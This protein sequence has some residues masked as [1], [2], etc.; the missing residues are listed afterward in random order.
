MIGQTISHYRIVEKLG[1]GGMGVVY[2]AED[3]KLGRHVALKFL[4]DDLAKD[5]QALARFRREAKAASSL[6]HPNICTIHEIDESG[7][8]SFIAME[9]LEGQTLRHM[10]GGKPLEIGTMLDLGIQIADALDAAHSKAIIHRDIKPANIFVTNRGQAK[11]LDFGLVKVTTKPESV[12]FTE[13]TIEFEQSLTSPGCA[14]G[15]VAYMSPEQVRAKELDTRTDLFSFGAVLYEMCT[16]TLPF[17]GESSGV[18]FKAILDGTPASAMRLNPDLPGELERIVN[19]ALE[20]DCKLRYQHASEMRSE[21]QRFKRDNESSRQLAAAVAGTTNE[22]SI[23]V[24]PFTNMS[25]DPENEFFADGITEEIINALTQ[26]KDLRVA[27]RTSAFSFKGKHVDLRTI[28][29]RLNVRTVL[30]GSVRKAGNRVRIMAQL[31]NVADGYQ[32]WS[33]RYDREL[34]DIFEVQ[35]DIARAISGRLQVTLGSGAQQ[36]L[37]K[38]ATNNFEAYQLCLKGRTLMYQRGL[39]ILRAMDCFKQAAALDAGYALAWAGVADSH[40]LGAYYGFAMP[41][42]SLPQAKEAALRAVELD[43]SLAE[44]HNALA[45]VRLFWDWDNQEAEREFLRAL[46][47]NAS[48]VQA[49]G[50]YGYLYLLPAGRVAE[51]IEQG[52]K[53]A[54]SDPLSGYANAILAII[55]D[56]AGLFEKAVQ[57]ATHALELDPANYLAR[58]ILHDALHSLGRFEDSVAVADL[59]LAM[60]G[61][62]MF[63]MAGLAVTYADWGKPEDAKALYGEMSSRASRE[64]IAPLFLAVAASA[65]GER[66]EAI[67][68]AQRAYEIRDPSLQLFGKCWPTSA[69]LREDARFVEILSKVGSR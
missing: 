26:I 17:R 60:S 30:E 22:A 2:K 53:V 62:H 28:G 49:R 41:L 8:L 58:F 11:I 39:G 59:A 34:R 68:L 47:L 38:V 65:A 4:P 7:G 56:F 32:L 40:N 52:E 1:G 10:I 19:R 29:D 24:L 18:I 43:G 55:C 37:V 13:P 27:A 25:A 23:A 63:T 42:S 31:T 15:T 16:G 51:A 45:F 35:D 14:L 3:L 57:A 36:T 54:G 20:K 9:L 69:R 67:R 64:Y 33:E 12:A 50:W 48:Y 21:L 46:A 44:A 6:N 5:P 66:E 61:R